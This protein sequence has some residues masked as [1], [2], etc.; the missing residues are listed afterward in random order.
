[1]EIEEYK[2]QLGSAETEL[3]GWISRWQD[4]S[5]LDAVDLIGL[6]ECMKLQLYVNM[7]KQEEE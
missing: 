6:L 1:V 2:K 4:E 3:C 7:D 5:D